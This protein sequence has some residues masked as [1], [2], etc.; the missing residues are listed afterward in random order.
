[1]RVGV[2]MPNAMPF[3]LERGFFLEWVRLADEAGF[4]TLSTLDRPNYDMWDPLVSLAAAATATEHIRLAT[5]TLP[6]PNRNEVL[7]AK[8]AAVIDRLSGG[9]LTLGVSLGSRPDDYEVFGATLE[10]RVARFRHQL[11]RI[12]QVWAE[13]RQSD[14]E[15]G[16]LGPPPVQDPGPPIWIG[17]LTERA[18]QRADGVP[19]TAAGMLGWLG[20]NSNLEVS[21]PTAT[22]VR[23]LP[24]LPAVGP[25]QWDC[26]G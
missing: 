20:G 22:G 8:Q 5:T 7:V 15:H 2:W 19:L 26:R 6:L 21:K 10:H 14:R 23:Q 18:R 9:R 4:D 16:V 25:R 11:A 13:A 1:M 17:A 3:G 24:G 12:R